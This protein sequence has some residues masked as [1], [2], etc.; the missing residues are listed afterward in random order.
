MNTAQRC[1]WYTGCPGKVVAKV[2]LQLAPDG[3][4]DA[5][6]CADCAD[7]ARRYQVPITYNLDEDDTPV[8]T[9]RLHPSGGWEV[10]AMVD[11]CRVHRRYYGYTEGEAVEQFRIDVLSPDAP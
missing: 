9:E 4:K 2:D 11:G 7:T 10:A 6:F 8:F 1:T 5:R 3:D